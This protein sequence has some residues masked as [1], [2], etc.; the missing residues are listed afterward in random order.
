MARQT[1]SS[2]GDSASSFLPHNLLQNPEREICSFDSAHLSALKTSGIFP[3]G[4]VFRPYDREI[5][6][7]M[8]STEWLC[9]NA[10]PFTLGL[11][12]PFPDFISEFFRI[13]NLSFSQTMP[14]LW[15]V[16]LVLDQIKNAHIPNLSI[17]DLPLAYRLR[18]HVSSIFLFYSTSNDPLILRA[19]RNEEE[20]KSKFFFVKRSSI[21]GGAHYPVKWLRRADFGKLAPPL[22]DL[23]KRSQAIRLLPEIERSFISYPTSS[24]QH[25]SS[26]MSDASKVPIL[27]DLE[28]LDGYPTPVQVKK[29]TSAVTS[30]KPAA[31]PR[32]NLRTR[33]STSKKRKGSETTA[34]TSEGFSYEELSFTE[35]LEPMPSFLN[36]VISCL[37]HLLHLYTEACETMKLQEVRIKQL[38][39]TVADQGTIDEAKTRHYKD[40]LKK[41]TQDAEVKLAAAQLNHD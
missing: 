2:S 33:A 8:A 36:K 35:S 30:S 25:S 32:P 24:S 26:N 34:P 7:D 1:R 27:L 16:L 23:E 12:F 40:K 14:V 11:R 41:V 37:Q 18:S 15:R 9:F 6:S 28:E 5:R 20:W 22:A 3:E 21:P 31:A 29:E 13:T 38:D 19:I 39:T 17:H 4:T 10:F